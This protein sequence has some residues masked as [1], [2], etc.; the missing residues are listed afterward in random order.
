VQGWSVGL[1]TILL[2]PMLYSA[3]HTNEISEG[4]VVYCPIVVQ[5]YCTRV[6]NV[7]GRRE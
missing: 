5:Q 7:G 6:G 2:L 3:W 4:G 1:Y